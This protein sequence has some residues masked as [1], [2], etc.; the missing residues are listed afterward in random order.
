VV[1]C[2]CDADEKG[3][4]GETVVD[5]VRLFPAREEVRWT[6]RVHEQILPALRRQGIP[7][8]WSDVTVRHTGYTDTALRRRKLARDEAILREDLEDRPG[9]PFILFNLGSIAI[10]RQDWPMAL[11]QLTRSLAS[12]ASSDSITR[13]LYALIARSHQMLGEADR[14]LAACAAGLAIDPEDAELLFREAVIRRNSGDRAGAEA[15]WRRVL[16]LKRPEQ[17][18]SLDM[19]I[20]GH[21]TRR[22][23]AALAEERGD[24]AEALQFW[25]DILAECPGDRDALRARSRLGEPKPDDGEAPV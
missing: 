22:N 11:D 1:R 23:L 18:A 8:H 17:F 13:K 6:Y 12:S 19:G 7:V 10:E 2:A 14:A 21:L 25:N 9:D 3:G 15:C 4:G 16:T 5:H 20:Y 24:R